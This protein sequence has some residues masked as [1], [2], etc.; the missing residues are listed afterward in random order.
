MTVSSPPDP[1]RDNALN[2]ELLQAELPGGALRRRDLSP[3]ALRREPVRSR[4][5]ARGRRRRRA[6]RALRAHPPAVP[7]SPRRGP[8]RVLAARGRAQRHATK[9]L[10][11]ADSAPRST[12]EAAAAGWQLS[13]GVCNDKSIG[14]VVK[15]MGWKTPGPL[16]VK[17]CVPMH[18]G[19]GVD[20]HARRRRVPRQRR[21][22]RPH[23][24]ARRLR[25]RPVDQLVHHRVPALAARLPEHALRA[26]LQRRPPRRSRPPI[27]ASAS[28][29]RSC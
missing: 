4:D 15:Y 29:P 26:A 17:L 22:R 21:V 2:T 8:R 28:A 24:R 12:T 25:R 9:G 13:T 19:R 11:P 1:T 18:T 7:R 16:P 14:A 27:R 3:L 6:R 5:P 20:Q 23:R 10:L